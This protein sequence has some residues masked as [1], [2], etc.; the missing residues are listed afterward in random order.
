[1]S[2]DQESSIDHRVAAYAQEVNNARQIAI[3]AMFEFDRVE[4]SHNL[5]PERVE[6]AQVDEAH[7]DLQRSVLLYLT[8]LKPYLDKDE[9]GQTLNEDGDADD[10]TFKDL[11]DHHGETTKREIKTGDAMDPNKTETRE[12][13]KLQPAAA[14]RSAIHTLNDLA[15]EKGY[16]PEQKI[17]VADP[18]EATV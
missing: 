11:I 18:E 8:Y 13:P 12:V 16:L 14:L 4:Q 9:L 6:Q 7:W 2:S 15:L 10:V 1:M 3:E 17:P 5:N